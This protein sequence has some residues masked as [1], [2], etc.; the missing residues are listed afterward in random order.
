M[1][2]QVSNVVDFTVLVSAVITGCFTLGAVFLTN[3]IN[4][5][6]NE[7]LLSQANQRER[8]RDRILKAE[9]LYVKFDKWSSSMNS[10]CYRALH[11][12]QVVNQ[13]ELLERSMENVTTVKDEFI[14][15]KMLVD[16]YF[17]ELKPELDAVFD[18]RDRCVDLFSTLQGN[19]TSM[20]K[21]QNEMTV[22][23]SVT[24]LFKKEIAAVT[25]S[26]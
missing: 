12:S 3:R 9:S 20:K 26:L 24:E 21:L 25:A 8:N 18:A 19:M 17:P 16:I 23:E 6:Q 5:S 13:S 14:E 10:V 4:A 2:S 1:E 11:L 7:K 15:I 22:F